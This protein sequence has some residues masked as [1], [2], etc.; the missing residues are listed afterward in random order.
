MPFVRIDYPAGKGPDYRAAL[1]DAVATA[2]TES[3]C[4]PFNDRFQ[5]LTEHPSGAIAVDQRHLGIEGSNDPIL[6]QAFI[7]AGRS[8]EQKRSFYQAA[9][10][11][12]CERTAARKEDIIISIVEVAGEDWSF[13]NGDA[14]YA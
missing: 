5:I 10:S 14:Q 1:S 7:N 11:R 8:S 4:V 12:I 9:V 13:G 3:L 2:L 6:I